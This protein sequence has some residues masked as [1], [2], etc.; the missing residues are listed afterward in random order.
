TP[1]YRRMQVYV[2]EII[3]AAFSSLVITPGETTTQDVVW[4]MRQRVHDLGL[5][6]WFQPSVSIQRRGG[7][8]TDPNPVIQR[9]DVLHTDFGLVAMGLATDTQHMGYVLR[10]G[11]TEAPAGLQRALANANRLQ[12]ILFEET[13]VGRTGNEILAAVLATMRSE[14]LNGTMYSHP[15]GDHGHGAGP[16][17]GLWD[18]QTGVPGRGDPP[19]IPSMW[20]STELQVTTPVPEWDGQPVRMMQEEEAEITGDGEMRWVLRRQT[21]LHL[22]H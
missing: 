3:S 12:D 2:H 7:N 13:R 10:E 5:G 1:V 16:L 11:E 8:P 20:F 17:I 19:V 14:G 9:G 22:I 6:T 18:Y 15:I 4:W 21:E